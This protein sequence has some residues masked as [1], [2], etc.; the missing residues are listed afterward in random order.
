LVMANM[1][2]KRNIAF[3]IGL[4]LMLLVQS[5]TLFSY[6]NNNSVTF[7]QQFPSTTF[8]IIPRKNTVFPQR[9]SNK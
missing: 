8:S 5:C 1:W 2:W 3:R 7:L 6:T 4:C 9:R